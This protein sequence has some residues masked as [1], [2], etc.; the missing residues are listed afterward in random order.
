MYPTLELKNVVC[1]DI[2]DLIVLAELQRYSTNGNAIFTN[3]E[4]SLKRIDVYGFDFDYTLAHYSKQL[5]AYIYQQARDAL[6]DK[7]NVSWG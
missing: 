3:S 1:C 6:I 2:Y 5:D 4:F 7:L